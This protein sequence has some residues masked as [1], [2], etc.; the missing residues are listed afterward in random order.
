M[1]IF[2]LRNKRH[3][4]TFYKLR[5]LINILQSAQYHVKRFEQWFAFRELY[6]TTRV[7][8]GPGGCTPT[9]KL[10]EPSTQL[11]LVT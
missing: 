8:Q 10:T 5:N 1:L 3:Y 2:L 6:I 9:Q 7:D 4:T 11:S